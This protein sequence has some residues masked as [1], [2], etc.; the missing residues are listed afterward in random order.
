MKYYLTHCYTRTTNLGHRRIVTISPGIP[1]RFC[2]F[3][4]QNSWRSILSP[5]HTEIDNS[6]PPG[7]PI[8][9]IC[10]IL[11][12]NRDKK[13]D[14]CQEQCIIKTLKKRNKKNS[15]P[16]F[17][18]HFSKERI[19]EPVTFHCFILNSGTYAHG[20]TGTNWWQHFEVVFFF[21]A[22]FI[23]TL[24]FWVHPPLT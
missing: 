20:G 6:P 24:E 17:N 9:H 19:L 7:H 16:H 22:L 18:P 15:N 14:F 3:L 13:I 23:K 21:I 11:V 2:Y 4:K 5:G 8:N 1:T 10:L 12:Q